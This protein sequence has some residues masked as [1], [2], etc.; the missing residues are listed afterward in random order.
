VEEVR[1]TPGVR[2]AAAVN[3]L[4]MGTDGANVGLQ[5]EGRTWRTGE[6]PQVDFR[7]VTPG[8][9]ETMRIPLRA[10]RPLTERDDATSPRAVLISEVLAR[11]LWPGES[12]L[13]K[14]VACCSHPDSADWR[15][16]VGVVGAVRHR[17]LAEAAPEEM[18]VP[19]QQT[20][21][22][23]RGMTLVARGDDPASLTPAL[24]RAVRTVDP[25][26]AL[27]DVRT[28]REV[29]SRTRAG[30]RFNTLLLTALALTGLV[31]AVVGIYG[32]ISY[33]VSQRT[34]EIGVR[35]A[36]GATAR[37]VVRLVVREG[38]VMG[39]VGLAIG[40]ALALVA[41][42]VLRALLFGVTPTD[43]L[44]LAGSCAVLFAAALLASYLPARRAARVEPLVSLR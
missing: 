18:Y 17:G 31:L 22:P 32:V 7:V 23:E 9:L 41:A 43:P 21:W 44:V 5:V 1:A 12:A 34:H 15:E 39:L 2:A 42:R 6:M 4:P 19:F 30:A 38:V 33:F 35:L 29:M 13:G 37:D 27:S 14:R 10:G 28:L 8:Y 26:L 3:S 24:R 25:T 40:V 16:V 20:P 36:L 11:R